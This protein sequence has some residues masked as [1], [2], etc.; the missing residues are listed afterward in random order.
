MRLRTCRSCVYHERRTFYVKGR[1][2]ELDYCVI[3]R[4]IVN[5]SKAL[6]CP[7]YRE[8]KR[9]AGATLV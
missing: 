5:I 1:L 4:E 2:S 7:H 8:K 3:R 9:H 6:L